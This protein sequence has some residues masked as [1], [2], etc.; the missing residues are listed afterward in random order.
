MTAK[1]IDGID[2]SKGRPNLDFNAK[3][4]RAFYVTKYS[5]QAKM[6]AIRKANMRGRSAPFV[7][8]FRLNVERC[9]EQ[10][11][12]KTFSDYDEWA[13]FVEKGRNGTLQH[14]YDAVEGPCL[15][16]PFAFKSKKKI[17]PVPIGHQ[18]AIKSHDLLHEM[19]Y[20]GTLVPF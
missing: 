19:Y 5:T 3:N 8:R 6:W 18:I 1:G 2:L 17:H 20:D 4:E 7:L 16:N 9:K 10:Y 12:W 14:N 15:A 11:Q 13:L